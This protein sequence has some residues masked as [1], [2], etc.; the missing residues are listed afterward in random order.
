MN[1]N[2]LIVALKEGVTPADVM[3]ASPTADNNA[4]VQRLHDTGA[5]MAALRNNEQE[6]NASD[7]ELFEKNVYPGLPET[8]KQ[9]FRM[10][11]VEPG[12][13]NASEELFN[14]LQKH[15][16]VAFVQK[17]EL[18]E[19][20]DNPNDP[21]LPEQWAVPKIKCLQAW[22]LSQGN[23]VVIAIVDTGVDAN[24]PDVSGNLWRNGQGK[25]GYDFSDNNDNPQDYQG[26]G[27]HCA[28]IAAA[29][30]NNAT[31]IVGVAPK[32]KIMSVKIFPNAYDSVC[33]KAIKYA[34]D[35]G[36]KVISNSWGP[37]GRRPSNPVIE[38]TI[39]YAHSKGAVV[40]FAAGNSNDD[41]QYYSPANYRK[42]ISV[43]ATDKNDKRATFSNYGNLVTVAAPGVGILSLQF[44]TT[45]YREMSGTSM[46][47]PHVAG[48]AALVLMRNKTLSA[49]R[50]KYF[51]EN[52]GDTIAS[53]KPVGKRINSHASVQAT[54]ATVAA[55]P[56]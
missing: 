5:H 52:F 47:C 45:G 29:I 40:V 9:L 19:L 10:Y 28:G 43:G 37:G 42:V 54:P 7:D 17:D 33:S 53:D 8:E 20:Y 3:P 30:A 34:A 26:H 39:D 56:V 35:N 27:S 24:H 21:R 46:A 6:T 1:T 11:V 49:D 22:P 32:A 12:S 48:L 25:F 55:E 2:R 38:S 51:I 41:V 31:G 15:E 14:Y 23:D 4:I 16:G 18:N 13:G 44:N 36:A 50:V